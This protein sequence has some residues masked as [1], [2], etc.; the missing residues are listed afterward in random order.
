MKIKTILFDLDGVLIESCQ[1]HV[2]ALNFALQA[3]AGFKISEEE[4]VSH[5]NGLPTKTKLNILVNK[6]LIS[7]SMVPSIWQLKQEKTVEL[8]NQRAILDIRKITMHR[9][10][11]ASGMQLGCV[12]N[13][14]SEVAELALTKTG[15]KEFMDVIISSNDVRN[16]KPC[17]EGY[18]T[19]MVRLTTYPKETLIIEDSDAGYQAAVATGAHIMRI[20]DSSEVT[21]EN[22]NSYLGGK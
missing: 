10:L 12:T 17:G 9:C 11:K 5:Y 4:H 20:K 13:T 8:I 14:T 21:L 22:I 3:I 7:Q 16:L 2:D 19:A 6:N 15:Q 1:W 18:I